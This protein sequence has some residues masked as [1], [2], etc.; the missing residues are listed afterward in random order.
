M[1]LFAMLLGC[2]DPSSNPASSSD[3]TSNTTTDT[4]VTL[5]S[6]TDDAT[7]GDTPSQALQVTLSAPATAT[8]CA[9]VTVTAELLG[10]VASQ[11][12]SIEGWPLV[13]GERSD[14]GRTLTFQAPVVPM[15]TELTITLVAT[16]DGAR[17]ATGSAVVRVEATPTGEGLGDGMALDCAPFDHGVASGD[18][19]T[20]SVLLWTRVEPSDNGG[21]ASAEVQW[22][23]ARDRWLSDVVAQGTAG[24]RAEHDHTVQIE[25]GE[26]EP[27]TTYYYQFQT[28]GGE[29]SALGRTRTAPEGATAQFRLASMSCS[30]IFS[31]YFNAYGRIAERDDL[32]L[33]VHWG[34]YLYDFVDENEQVRVP[35]PPPVDPS[36]QA[37][38]QERHRYYLS[39]PNLRAA[40]A[41]HPWVVIWDNHDVDDDGDRS[42]RVTEVFRSYVPMRLTDPNDNRIGYRALRFGDLVDLIVVDALLHRDSENM[43]G[44]PQWSW[45]EEQITNSTATWRVLGNQKL[46]STLF[47]PGD[48]LSVGNWEDRPAQRTR[49]FA[50]LGTRGDNLI[51]SGDLHFTLAADLVDMPLDPM[52]PYDPTDPASADRS[53]GVE[54]LATSISRGNFDEQLCNGLCD[55]VNLTLIDTL[56]QELARINAHYALAELI[57]HGYGILDIT[58]ERITAELWFSPI[59]TQT[60]DERLGATLTV[61]QGANRW[62][63]P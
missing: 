41:A 33:V 52:N 8:G 17:E 48:L 29:R 13:S 14:D 10:T 24:V 30:S 3:N 5:T 22:V 31:G 43:L 44:E 55:E 32:D 42:Q 54:L 53:V 15:D 18:P 46:V 50:L 12:W 39:D 1:L 47:I 49:L 60:R 56:Q 23:M 35:E 20:N 26:L 34:D 19:S 7:P 11:A 6:D 2:S 51:L 36:S 45:L 59:R 62:T 16:G 57:E 37:Q 40:R 38:W 4:D 25:V 61:E 9:Q 63:R 27:G 21:S 58:P 28:A